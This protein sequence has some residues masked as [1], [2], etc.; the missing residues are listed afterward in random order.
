[1]CSVLP[2]LYE[3]F[4]L[5]VL[6]AMAAGDAGRRSLTAPRSRTPRGG[7]GPARRPPRTPAAVAEAV[8]AQPPC[9]NERL[10]A[11][12]V[13]ARRA[14]FPWSRAIAGVDAVVGRLL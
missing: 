4:G 9:A 10:R 13:G 11:A 7:G 1:M 14:A 2:S 12:G 8:L 3:G 5:P 6:E